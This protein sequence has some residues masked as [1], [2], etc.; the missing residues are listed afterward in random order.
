M[1]TLHEEF[2]PVDLQEK[3]LADFDQLVT[4]PRYTPSHYE[5]ADWFREVVSTVSGICPDS[6]SMQARRGNRYSDGHTFNCDLHTDIGVHRPDLAGK[7]KFILVV[8]NNQRSG[9]IFV[10][11]H[12]ELWEKP[13]PELFVRKNGA[14]A[15]RKNVAID[16]SWE[17]A[18]CGQV[19]SFDMIRQLHGAAPQ[20][21]GDQKILIST[22]VDTS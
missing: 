15:V 1:Y 14:L 16:F 2:M 7:L 5:A 18:Q 6:V 13:T 3:L 4:Q 9:T 11:D 8:A 20:Y 17:Q 22:A 10:D 21:E 12:P 19:C